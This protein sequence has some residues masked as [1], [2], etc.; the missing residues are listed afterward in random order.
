MSDSETPQYNLA[1]VGAATL[2]G[3]EVKSL[4]EERGFPVGRL[5][6]LDVGEARG[7]LTE[8]GEEPMIIQPVSRDSFAN[9]AFALFASSP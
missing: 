6:L 8:F 4:L 7:Q 3:K 1:L 9:M 5:A 2:K